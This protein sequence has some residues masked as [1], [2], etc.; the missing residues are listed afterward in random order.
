M[1]EQTY[2]NV[3]AALQDTLSKTEWRRSHDCL[4]EYRLQVTTGSTS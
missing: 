2:Q 4:L 3:S 1:T